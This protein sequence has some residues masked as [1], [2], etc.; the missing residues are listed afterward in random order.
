MVSL[1]VRLRWAERVERQQLKWFVYA[2]ALSTVGIVVAYAGANVLASDL[3][4]SIGYWESQLAFGAL[5]IFTGI[6]ILRYR[7][8][9][10]DRI[11]NRTPRLG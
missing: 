6:A 7:L 5:P 2:A 9:D 3:V 8:Y 11:I 4:N 1:L 10:I